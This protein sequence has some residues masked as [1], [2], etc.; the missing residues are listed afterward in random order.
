MH[1]GLRLTKWPFGHIRITKPQTGLRSHVSRQNL[2]YCSYIFKKVPILCRR[3][4]KILTRLR[5]CAVW[6]GSSLFAYVLRSLF[7]R[8]SI[9]NLDSCISLSIQWSVPLTMKVVV[10][11]ATTLLHLSMSPLHLSLSSDALMESSNHK[12]A[13]FLTLS[14]YCFLFLSPLL[15]PFTVPCR[16]ATGALCGRTTYVSASSPWLGDL[17][18]L[19]LHPGSCC[20]IPN[21]S[22]GPCRKYLEAIDTISTQDLEFFL[23]VLL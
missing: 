13:L 19:R 22:L 15:A 12:A 6:A 8:R 2:L 17:Q 14:I 21:S 3:T 7:S 10:V 18:A 11:V 16:H 1:M 4:A 23:Q 9:C 20:E 5:G